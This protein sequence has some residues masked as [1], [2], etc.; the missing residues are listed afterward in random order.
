M[1]L[2]WSSHIP[3]GNL[4]TSTDLG[5][6]IAWEPTVLPVVDF[7]DTYEVHAPTLEPRRFFRLRVD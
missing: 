7:S 5:E 6:T 1:I 4:E 3:P 2:S